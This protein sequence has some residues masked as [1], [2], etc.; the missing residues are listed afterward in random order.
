[1]LDDAA[2]GRAPDQS[3]GLDSNAIL[4]DIM[5]A[6]SRTPNGERAIEAVEDALEEGDLAKAREELDA[7][8]Q[9]QHGDTR[10]TA[11]L[12]ATINNLE[13]LADARD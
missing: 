6:D 13:V 12:E 7:L 11:R 4:E 9:L 3:Y 5:G 10:D 1:M 2:R 8:K